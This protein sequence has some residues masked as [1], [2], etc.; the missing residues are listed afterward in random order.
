MRHSPHADIT[1]VLDQEK[2]L[3]SQPFEVPSPHPSS[4]SRAEKITRRDSGHL[5][6]GRSQGKRRTNLTT[7]RKQFRHFRCCMAGRLV[8]DLGSKLA[9]API[10]PDVECAAV[11]CSANAESMQRC[12][13][14]SPGQGMSK[15]IE[16]AR[17][18]WSGGTEFEGVLVLSKAT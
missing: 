3:F 17:R 16:T 10:V 18:G 5:G 2:F 8:Q 1:T 15:Q 7:C 13:I 4:C 12:A 9:P 14:L 11:N 6:H